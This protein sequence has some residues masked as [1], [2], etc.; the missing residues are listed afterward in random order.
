MEKVELIR[1]QEQLARTYGPWHDNVPFGDGVFSIS[2]RVT[3]DQLRLRSI[4]QA[5]ADA[6]D[7]PFDRIRVL[8]LG[9]AEG[10]FALEFA[11]QGA[12]VVAFEGRLGNAEKIRL[13]KE[14]LGL[15]RLAVVQSDV[16][17]L[18]RDS[19]GEFD[20]VLCLGV[21]YHLE[22]PSAVA[23]AHALAEV[24]RR[25]AIVDTHVGSK[26]NRSTT[27][28]GHTYWGRLVREFDPGSSDQ[29]ARLSRVSIGN[30]ES[31]WFTR[32]S[33]YNLLL[34]AGFTSAMDVCVPRHEKTSDRATLV[35]FKGS[36]LRPASVPAA[37][38]VE[39][40]RWS[41]RQHGNL[42]PNQTRLG[43]LKRRLAPWTPAP[44]REWVLQRQERRRT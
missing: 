3:R 8:D 2:D 19:H 15:D 20:L 25:V 23:L 17:A 16:R 31:I 35:A 5:A 43:E 13:A 1:R 41:E 10:A 22:G 37:G 39:P 24:C 18:S 11:L 29:E 34:D 7:R 26:G 42:H 4:S 38:D 27:S 28:E 9:A 40:L 21:L 30:P 36:P 6:L 44:V 32:P 12:E 33:L 14:A